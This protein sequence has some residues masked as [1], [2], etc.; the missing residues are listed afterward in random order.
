MRIPGLGRLT[1]TPQRWRNRFVPGGLILMYHRITG[2]RPDPWGCCV[3]PQRFA[4]HLAVLRKHFRP[5]PLREITGSVSAEKPSAF[6]RRPVAITFD[7]GYADNLHAA[8]PL[9]EKYGVPATIFVT[10]GGV[11]S[12]RECW[13]DEMERLLL[14]PGTLPR[15]LRLKTDEGVF[16]W[17]LGEA[18]SYSAASFERDRQW[19]ATRDPDPTPRHALYQAL[20]PRLQLLEAVARE[21][22]I[23]ELRDW[24]GVNPTA[25]ET[26]RFLTAEE[27]RRLAAGELIEIGAHTVTH[28]LISSLPPA[29]QSEEISR[30]RQFLEQTLERPVTSFAYPHGNYA[31]E[32]VELVRQA[33]FDRACATRKGVVRAESDLFLLPRFQVRDWGGREFSAWLTHWLYD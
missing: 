19:N 32:T 28:P 16:E 1:R 30:S 14:Q 17:D 2:A 18:A 31:G 15:Q 26:H 8:G 3:S 12:D 13:W 11:G 25:R 10:T 20:Y 29:A 9:L 22:V 33:G 4:E 24:S 21:K 5:V 27:L 7:D 23:A 6:S